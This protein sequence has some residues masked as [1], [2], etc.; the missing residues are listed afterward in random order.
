M[1]EMKKGEDILAAV[2]NVPDIQAA[3]DIFSEKLDD[4]N[5]KKLARISNEDALLKIANAIAM[6]RPDTVFVNTGSPEDIDWIRNYSLL[7]GE[8]KKLAKEGHTIH[9]DLPQDQAG[10]STRPFTSSTA[11]S[12]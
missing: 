5:Q 4:S 3:R 12:R 2:G 11:G 1:L 7:K 9:F 10:W 6:C 8:E